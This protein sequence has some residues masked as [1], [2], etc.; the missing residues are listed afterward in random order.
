MFLTIIE[1]SI[2]TDL[3]QSESSCVN[4][5]TWFNRKLGCFS[6]CLWHPGLFE[7]R[8]LK[9]CQMHLC[10]V[11]YLW[12]AIIWY[13]IWRL[14]SVMGDSRQAETGSVFKCQVEKILLPKSLR[15]FLPWQ[16]IC[17]YQAA[18]F[19]QLCLSTPI[20]EILSWECGRPVKMENYSVHLH[21][22]SSSTAAES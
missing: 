22:A 11:L 20:C 7:E 6:F 3:M 14:V 4:E 16:I 12:G 15:E 9:Q 13:S 17:D 2:T 19:R 10:S 18:L 8:G 5:G 1:S 21:W